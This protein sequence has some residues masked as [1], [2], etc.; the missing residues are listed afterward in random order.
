MQIPN[1]I[2]KWIIDDSLFYCIALI[3]ISIGSFGLGRLSIN[4]TVAPGLPTQSAG[5]SV[6][7]DP[8]QT[9]TASVVNNEGRALFVGSKNG[10]KYHALNCPGASQIKEENKVSF[11]S[12]EE[13]KAQG[14]SP[15]ANCKF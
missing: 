8:T 3:L 15:A 9:N 14:Y 6:V 12:E 5:I 11:S 1:A 10:T 7:N 13:A 2:K 4:A